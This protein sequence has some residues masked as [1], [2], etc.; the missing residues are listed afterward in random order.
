MLTD[1]AV[2]AGESSVTAEV[3]TDP[4]SVNGMVARLLRGS[5]HWGDLFARHATERTVADVRTALER[6]RAA[7]SGDEGSETG[8]ADG[9]DRGRASTGGDHGDGGDDEPRI[10]RIVADADV[11]AADLLVG[12]EARTALDA[13]RRHSWLTLVATRQLLADARAVIADLADPA[14][15]SAW[16]ALA[17]DRIVLVEQ[18]S[19]DHPA[20][21]AAYQGRAMHVLSYDPALTSAAAGMALR[22]RA[23]ISVREPQ[24]FLAVFDPERVYP[25][26]VEGEYPGPDRDPRE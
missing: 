1:G 26:V 14:L 16:H 19:G 25:T 17:T 24:A 18:P 6:R 13:V 21:A 7:A 5:V 9:S 2:V 3:P 8:A 23:P 12:G 4:G 20:L 11:L 10:D 15:A 22:D